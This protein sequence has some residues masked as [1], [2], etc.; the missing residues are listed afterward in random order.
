[1]DALLLTQHW[2]QES[3][4]N[5]TK[6]HERDSI[7]NQKQ[8]ERMV[9]R[10]MNHLKRKDYGLCITK[11]DVDR[12]VIRT[13]VVEK[14]FNGATYAGKHVIQINLNYW[15][16]RGKAI[17]VKEYDSYNKCA[18]IGGRTVSSLEQALWIVVAHEVSHHVQYLRGPWTSWLKKSY[19]KPHGD[20]FRMIYA[21][22]R[23][24]LINPMLDEAA[25]EEAA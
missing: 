19:S 17:K 13:R 22:L 5:G 11:G 21:M 6:E 10:C 1:M 20:G 16:F 4:T 15:Q 9:R 8:I 25:M 14:N 12:A 23:S 18:V 2:Q 24:G 7:M 3:P